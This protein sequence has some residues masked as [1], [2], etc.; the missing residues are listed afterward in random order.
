MLAENRSGLPCFAGGL[1]LVYL[2]TMAVGTDRAAAETSSKFPDTAATPHDGSVT[3]EPITVNAKR[4]QAISTAIEP[5]IGASTYTVTIQAIELQPGGANN[6]L[7]Q[8]LLQ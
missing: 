6:T 7:N 1:A 3:L 8:V 2:F 5:Q 4:L